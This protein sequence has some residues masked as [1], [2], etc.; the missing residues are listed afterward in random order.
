MKIKELESDQSTKLKKFEKNRISS[1]E[2]QII[3]HS[4]MMKDHEEV[5]KGLDNKFSEKLKNYGN[6]CPK[7]FNFYF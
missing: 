2:R 5:S 4:N 3:T 7:L 6:F 1:I